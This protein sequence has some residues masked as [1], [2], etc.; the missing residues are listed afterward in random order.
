M[1]D[2]DQNNQ[3]MHARALMDMME[4]MQFFISEMLIF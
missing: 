3:S 4:C 1:E 2:G